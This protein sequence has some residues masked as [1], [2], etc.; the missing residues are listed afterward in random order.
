[1]CSSNASSRSSTAEHTGACGAS[2]PTAHASRAS[3]SGSEKSARTN[4]RAIVLVRW[5]TTRSSSGS[6]RAL[7]RAGRGTEVERGLAVEH[8]LDL[9]AHHAAQLV[10]A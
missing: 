3:A 8:A 9:R 5:V 4:A 6:K 10:D 2:S 1:M 7:R